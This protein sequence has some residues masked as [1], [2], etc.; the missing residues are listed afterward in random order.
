ME[1]IEVY[2]FMQS[3]LRK[4]NKNNQENIMASILK[5]TDTGAS[6]VYDDRLMPLF[7][8]MGNIEI[9]RATEVEFDDKSGEWVA[10]HLE[11]K[12][13]IARGKNRSEVIKREVEFLENNLKNKFQ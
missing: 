2:S 5:I 6:C 12:A 9:K 4:Y 10:T 8:A 1:N 11:T 3:K 13:I 7:E